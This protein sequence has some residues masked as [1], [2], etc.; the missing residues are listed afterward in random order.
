MK[1][2][3]VLLTFIVLALASPTLLQ[4]E[5]DGSGNVPSE[6]IVLRP[7]EPKGRPNAPSRIR[8]ECNYYGDTLEFT[9]PAN[10]EMM[11]VELINEENSTAGIVYSDSPNFELP[12]LCGEFEIRCTTDDGKTYYGMIQLSM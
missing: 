9:F 7:K 6:T 10:V 4:A 5:K 1:H 2:L 8:I 11:F 3:K 12:P